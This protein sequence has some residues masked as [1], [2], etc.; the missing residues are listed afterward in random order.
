M[1][2]ESAQAGC[3]LLLRQSR[4]GPEEMISRCDIRE[5]IAWC[6]PPCGIFRSP[7]A[8]AFHVR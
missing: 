6:V 4:A 8:M 1:E 7:G 3:G 2:S 5:A